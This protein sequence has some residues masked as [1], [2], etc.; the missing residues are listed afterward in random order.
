MATYIPQVAEDSVS[1]DGELLVPIAG[2]RNDAAASRIGSDGDYGAI[3]LDIAGRVGITDL[4]G[5]ISVDDNGGSL[6]I[7]DGGG[8]ITVDGSVSVSGTVSISGSVAVT[9]GGGSLTVDDGGLSLTVDGTVTVVDGGGSITVDGTVSISGSV[10]VTGPLTDTELRATPVDVLGP[11]T[12]TELRATPVDVLGPLTDTELRASPVAVTGPLTD[13]ELRATPVPVSVSS[14]PLPSGAATEATLAAIKVSVEIMDDWDESD[15]AKVNP[16]VGQAGVQGGA[17][18]VSANTQRIAIATDA[19]VVE[20]RQA[21]ASNLNAQV[22][23]AAASGASASGNPVSTG[24]LA[25][26]SLPTAVSNAQMVRE[27][28]DVFGRGV[29]IP[30]APRDLVDDEILTITSSTSVTSFTKSTASTFYDIT[31]IVIE[32][33]S[34]TG[35]EVIIYD[36]DGT[37]ERVRFYVPATDTRGIVYQVPLKAASSGVVWKAKTV[38]SV[39]SVYITL[40]YV[41]NK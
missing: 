35:T 32:N 34:S 10:A 21:T 26:T 15:R 27:M 7:D 40:N 29:V 14:L 28:S 38:T 39:A 3:A 16:I 41:K 36:N 4:G 31:S 8:S 25:A 1:A 6:T 17:G 9:D 33:K 23:G 12:D 13:T 30:Q 5:S 20:A 18:A 2:I 11:L 24:L 19:N 37:T 22:V